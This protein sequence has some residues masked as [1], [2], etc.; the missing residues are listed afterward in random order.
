M[1]FVKDA[2]QLVIWNATTT[3]SHCDNH[4]IT[5]QSS[6]DGNTPLLGE[7]ASVGE[8][9]YQHLAHAR[10]IYEQLR[11]LR[12]DFGPHLHWFVLH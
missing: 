5:R 9:V 11:K 7:A 12:L 8:Q 2:L 1:V 4:L 6:S 3:V 10:S